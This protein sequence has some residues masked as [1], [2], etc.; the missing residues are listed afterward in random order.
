MSAVHWEAEGNLLYLYPFYPNPAALARE[1]LEPPAQ[2]LP[3][4]LPQLSG[5][6]LRSLGSI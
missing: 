1:H 2:H 6:N 4:V 3:W 5:I